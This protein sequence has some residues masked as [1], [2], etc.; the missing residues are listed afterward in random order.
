MTTPVEIAQRLT[1]ALGETRDALDRQSVE[2]S[3]MKAELTAERERGRRTRKVV[4]GV[5]ISLVLDLLLTV[6][7]AWA[8]V[9]ADSADELSKANRVNQRATCVAGNESRRDV[10]ELWNKVFSLSS[11]SPSPEQAR[12]V[13]EFK[14]F[15]E[16]TYADRDCSKI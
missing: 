12:R 8:V 5:V 3:K 7:V 11:T 16:Q 10:R 14:A 6:P 9:R 15:V 2:L 13:A 1:E 4:I